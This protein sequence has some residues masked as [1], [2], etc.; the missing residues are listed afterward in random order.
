MNS[1]HFHREE[2]CR[3][4]TENHYLLY[5]LAKVVLILIANAFGTTIAG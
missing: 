4:S 3:I 5:A 1:W 2:N